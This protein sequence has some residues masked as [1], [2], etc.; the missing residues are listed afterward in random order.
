MLLCGPLAV[1]RLLGEGALNLQL[2]RKLNLALYE[3]KKGTASS[4]RDRGV[5]EGD[6]QQLAM[7]GGLV[8]EAEGL[9]GDC[10]NG[11]A[12]D[13]G[14]EKMGYFREKGLERQKEGYQEG[15]A[16]AGVGTQL[17]APFLGWM[18][19]SPSSPCRRR[20]L[21]QDSRDPAP[22]PALGKLGLASSAGLCSSARP[23]A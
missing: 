14:E 5:E 15:F 6:V 2:E 23:C 13:L 21:L 7:G 16:A 9:R 20:F 3:G 10:V 4:T 22:A 12:A 8:V 17:S 11:S 18:P 19:S 1:L